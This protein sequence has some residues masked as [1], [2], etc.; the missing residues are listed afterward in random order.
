[1]IGVLDESFLGTGRPLAVALTLFEI[2]AH[3]HGVTVRSLRQRTGADS[4]YLSRLRRMLVAD[5][6]MEIVADP[7]DGRR[8]IARLTVAGREE[9]ADP[10]RR[11]DEIAACLLSAF[12]AEQADRLADALNTADRLLRCG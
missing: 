1:M 2:G 7:A 4:G 10:G 3:D 6:L 9:R 12:T 5:G 8:R 11:S